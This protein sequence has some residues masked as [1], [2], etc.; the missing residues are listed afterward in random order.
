MAYVPVPKR[1]YQGQNKNSV[2]SD[3]RQLIFFS[4]AAVVGAVLSV[5]EGNQFDMRSHPWW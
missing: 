5:H 2:K 4:L 3:K 1:P